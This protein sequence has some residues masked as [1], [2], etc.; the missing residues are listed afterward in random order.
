MFSA[1]FLPVCIREAALKADR[2]RQSARE[3]RLRKKAYMRM[4]E[5]KVAE[6][7]THIAAL[8]ARLRESQEENA[9]L[10]DE[11]RRLHAPMTPHA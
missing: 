7:K 5:Q 10:M 4:L 8:E 3:C 9:R 1:I 6:S 2:A 11:N